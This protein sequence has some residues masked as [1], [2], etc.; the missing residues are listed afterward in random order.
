MYR[1]ARGILAD[2][3]SFS[4]SERLTKA[5]RRLYELEQRMKEQVA[6]SCTTAVSLKEIDRRAARIKALYQDELDEI[7]QE[8]DQLTNDNST[9][10]GSGV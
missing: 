6:A 7:K 2:A 4:D 9:D 10:G 8:I 5:R 1:A 3:I